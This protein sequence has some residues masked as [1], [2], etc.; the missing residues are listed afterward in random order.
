M[1]LN[2]GILSAVVW[3][4][5]VGTFT[6]LGSE[7]DDVEYQRGQIFWQPDQ[8]GKIRGRSRILVPKGF[9]THLAYYYHP[10]ASLMCGFQVIDHPFDFKVAGVID[11]EDITET[12][13]TQLPT[14]RG[15]VLP[16]GS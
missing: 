8:H 12:D 13:F 1:S 9:Y 3:P 10:A 11:L 7:P 2:D 4:T 16:V 15:F 6:I 14:P 5:Y